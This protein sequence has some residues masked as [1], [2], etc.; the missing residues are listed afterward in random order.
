MN[1]S[2]SGEFKGAKEVAEY[3]F[4]I[5]ENQYQLYKYTANNLAGDSFDLTEGNLVPESKYYY[6]AYV[7]CY[8]RT[9]LKGELK[10]FTTLQKP[11]ITS[12]NYSAKKTV[13]DELWLTLT[14]TVNPAGL[15]IKD[16]GFF[17]GLVYDEDKLHSSH[18]TIVPCEFQGN[19]V[20]YDGLA[21]KYAF[22]L[23]SEISTY[24]KPYFVFEDG[25]EIYGKTKYMY[26]N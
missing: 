2:I 8:D 6:Y 25:T 19:T 24:I 4:Y 7:L 18:G 10:T 11:E 16:A 14:A 3:G 20:T 12:V 17:M 9:K 22:P 13:N 21:K 1:A 26:R 5:G 15:Q 23:S